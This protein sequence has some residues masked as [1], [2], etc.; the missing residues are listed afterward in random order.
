MARASPKSAIAQVPAGVRST[1]SGFKSRCRTPL[2]WMWS[3]PTQISRI[4]AKMAASRIPPCRSPYRGRSPARLA[5]A[6]GMAYQRPTPSSAP[7]ART[8]I[9]LGWLSCDISSSSRWNRA[10]V[11]RFRARSCRRT[12]TATWVPPG[13]IM[14]VAMCTMPKPP[15]SNGWPRTKRRPSATAGRPGAVALPPCAGR[16]L[17]S[18]GPHQD[19]TPRPSTAR[20]RVP[21]S[22]RAGGG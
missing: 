3:R 5:R 21:G 17:P 10:T 4:T 1:F 12:F 2:R 22:R 9:T 8:V 20:P 15:S 16:C 6:S 7:L 11:S 13:A 19:P 14:S 18:G